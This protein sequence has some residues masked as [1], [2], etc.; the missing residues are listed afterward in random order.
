MI[1]VYCL[2]LVCLRI[3]A[4]VGGG[5]P[6][7]GTTGGIERHLLRYGEKMPEIH[8]GYETQCAFGVAAVRCWW[9]LRW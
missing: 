7:L 2:C 4:Q 3:H 9:N 5:N 6:S 8:W 1:D